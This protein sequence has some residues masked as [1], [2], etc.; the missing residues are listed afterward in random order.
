MY[1]NKIWCTSNK[2]VS[3][4]EFYD[5]DFNDF[6][7]SNIR[8]SEG[9]LGDEV[10]DIA[11]LND[12][13]YIATNE[14][15]SF[16]DSGVDF[17]N[18]EPPPVYITSVRV[19]NKDTL[20]YGHPDFKY[21]NNNLH[22]GFNAIS[23]KSNEKI[24]YYYRL[25]SG[26]DTLSS[27]TTNREV[28]FLRLHPGDYNFSV[29]AMNNSGIWSDVPATY[30][31]CI[32]P[33]WWG[34][35]WFMMLLAIIVLAAVFIFYKFRIRKLKYD[36]E[37]ERRQAS[38]QL[39]AMRAQM[40]PHF[41]FN[42]MNSIRNYMQNHDMKSA[43]K[44]LTSFSRLVR[45][46]LDNSEVQEVTLDEELLAIRNYA[47]L[48]MQRFDNGF[49]FSIQCEEGI[50]LTETK[51]LSMLLQPYLENA[52]KHGISRAKCRGKIRIDIRKHN[53]SI[54]IAVEDNG[55][56]VEEAINWNRLHDGNHVSH[57][58]TINLERI[59]AYNKVY[60]RKITTRVIH[61]KDNDGNSSG[62]RVEVE[63]N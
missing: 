21:D 15:I 9:L 12:T 59:K 22:I 20:V 40:N 52:I 48:E 28:E 5:E 2:G 25:I 46:T 23:F 50:D 27:T 43:E 57:G 60:N 51:M 10:N 33:A 45:Y 56:G 29:I 7:I 24:K 37:M 26:N 19:N 17:I 61:L 30:S 18:R 11:V 16:F 13:V 41:I 44:Y 1:D 47:E 6:S 4:I 58:T 38:L 54:V 63:I 55:V 8:S 3:Y 34:T 32:L 39:T 49:D 53:D 36:F 62:T 31:F 35:W 42:V 14:G